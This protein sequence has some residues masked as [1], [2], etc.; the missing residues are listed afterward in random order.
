M[1]ACHLNDEVDLSSRNAEFVKRSLEW[2]ITYFGVKEGTKIAD[3][4]CGP[5]LYT[6]PL[7]KLGANVTGIDFSERSLEYARTRATEARVSIDYICQDYLGF[8]TNERFD[9]ILM[10]YCDLCALSPAQR[11][12]LLKKFRSMLTPQ[13]KILLDVSSL[14]GYA[15]FKEATSIEVSQLNGFWSP[16]PYYCLLNSF[17]YDEKKVTLDKYTIV[18]ADR[19]RTVYNWLQYY[20][21]ESL[22]AEFFAC[23]LNIQEYLGNVA[24]DKYD[25][26][27]SEFAV[28]AHPD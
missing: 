15:N 10:I 13:G 7:A 17:K 24:G 1:L 21:P 16:N 3:F 5:G 28:I 9:L 19:I 25:A 11:S 23:G 27:A 26:I 2:I 20:E 4:G 22:K 8:E 14:A 6:L 18:E 12:V